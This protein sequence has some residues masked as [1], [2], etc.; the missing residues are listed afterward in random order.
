MEHC[1]DAWVKDGIGAHPSKSNAHIAKP[2]RASPPFGNG[3]EEDFTSVL[4]LLLH[5]H[6]DTGYTVDHLSPYDTV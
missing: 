6:I 3:D 1:G 5:L 2:P 4:L